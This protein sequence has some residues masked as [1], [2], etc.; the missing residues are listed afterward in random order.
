MGCVAFHIGF[1][2]KESACCE[3]LS[4]A[5]GVPA[6]FDKGAL[7]AVPADNFARRLS[8]TR[9]FPDPPAGVPPVAIR[10]V[11]FSKSLL[12]LQ[13]PVS[14]YGAISGFFHLPI[15][16]VG[17]KQPLNPQTKTGAGSKTYHP[18]Q[19]E[20]SIFRWF[21]PGDSQGGSNSSG[22]ELLPP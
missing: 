1:L 22:S 6:P 7:R 2:K 21:H 10:T 5:S 18:S 4:H 13:S 16:S 20:G 8:T 17:S 11:I 19:S 9:H 3:S 15:D 12:P 14:F